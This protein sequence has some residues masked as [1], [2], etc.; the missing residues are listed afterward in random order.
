MAEEET[1]KGEFVQLATAVTFRGQTYNPSADDRED[2]SAD[3]TFPCLF[4]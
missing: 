3:E 4:R 2:S 1:W